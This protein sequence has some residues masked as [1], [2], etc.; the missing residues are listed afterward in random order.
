[1]TQRGPYRDQDGAEGLPDLSP[2]LPALEDVGTRLFALGARLRQLS[3]EPEPDVE[4]IA[5]AAGAVA[6]ISAGLSQDVA[7]LVGRVEAHLREER[8]ARAALGERLLCE[9]RPP[10]CPCRVCCWAL[11][12]KR[13]LNKG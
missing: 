8:R 12:W 7:A 5:E 10:V 9:A 6:N 1:M 4:E 2:L 3:G 11:S 13:R